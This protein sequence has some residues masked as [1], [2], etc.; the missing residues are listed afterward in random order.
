MFAPLLKKKMKDRV[1]KGRVPALS[2][3]FF[4][5]SIKFLGNIKPNN[6]R[7]MLHLLGLSPDPYVK[8]WI[9][10]WHKWCAST[11]NNKMT[12][13]LRVNTITLGLSPDPFVKFWIHHWHKWCASTPNNK[14]KTTLRV[15]TITCCHTPCTRLTSPEAIGNLHFHSIWHFQPFWSP[16]PQ[17]RVEALLSTCKA[18]WLIDNDLFQIVIYKTFHS[19]YLQNTT[20][21]IIHHYGI[22]TDV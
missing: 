8:F 3:Q 12:T 6:N 4:F 15:N 17:S 2:A 18:F 14:M 1:S 16:Q 20:H 5:V 19:H 13:T 22:G 10:H 9:H 7:F 11:P 21:L